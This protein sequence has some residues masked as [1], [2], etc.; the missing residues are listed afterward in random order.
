[1]A[2]SPV[3]PVGSSLGLGDDK[4]FSKAGV[5]SD[6][7]DGEVSD[8]LDVDASHSEDGD[9]SN[10]LYAHREIS[11][12]AE[13]RKA[14]KR[15]LLKIDFIILPLIASIYFLAALVSRPAILPF[16]ALPKANVVVRTEAMLAMRPWPA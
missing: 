8:R 9:H 4:S 5:S 14:E 6:P 11:L 3:T 13:E 10:G 12:T 7:G 15:F 1:M 16:F 2:Q